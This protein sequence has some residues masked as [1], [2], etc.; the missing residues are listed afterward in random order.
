MSEPSAAEPLAETAASHLVAHV[1]R[2]RLDDLASETLTAL[3]GEAYT[4]VEAVYV[5]DPVGRLRGLVP[6]TE[7]L[8][9]RDDRPL[10]ELM[11]AETPS[12]RFDA[13]QEHVAT[14]AVENGLT[15]VPVTDDDG[16]LL[17]VVPARAL[18][19]V[20]RR[21]HEEDIHRL[22]GM[23]GGS[24][25]AREA[26]TEPALRR[27]RHRLPWLLVG[28]AGSMVATAVVAS[29]EGTLEKRVAI[30]F[31]VPAIV[32]LADAIGT[33]TEAVV[34]RGLSLGRLRL[35]RMLWREVSAGILIGVVLG[36]V[37]IV[38]VALAFGDVR[39]GVAVGLAI[40][41]A[42]TIATSIGLL[43]P[44][45]LQQLGFD[46]AYGSGPVA[47]VVQDILSLLAYFTTAQLLLV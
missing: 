39:L 13:D 21:E 23:V 1:P 18:V 22:A 42:G 24:Q 14:V 10:G 9:S 31:F 12:V 15:A 30:A 4:D 7:L 11:Q 41:V 38:G 3:R 26:L 44:W 27:L 40:L 37:S 2:A 25:H 29:F 8:V 35:G 16:V 32:Y 17:G 34:V 46:P 6:L 47:T 33:Q 45:A 20:L 43:F 36:T 28:L 5:V 19:D